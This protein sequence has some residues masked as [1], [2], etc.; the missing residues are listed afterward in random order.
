MDVKAK[1]KKESKRSLHGKNHKLAQV[2]EQLRVLSGGDFAS[3][4][5]PTFKDK[6]EWM[7][8]YPLKPT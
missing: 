6:I 8:E 1:K 7:G 5:L 2:D 3:G 4:D